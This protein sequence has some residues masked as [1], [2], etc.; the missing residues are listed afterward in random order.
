MTRVI[1]EGEIVLSIRTE[2]GK[3]NQVRRGKG[4][5][6]EEDDTCD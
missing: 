3:N 4:R 5:M 1:K 2:K 6:K